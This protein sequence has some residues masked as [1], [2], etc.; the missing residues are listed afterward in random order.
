MH[1]DLAPL[2]R[3]PA[4]RIGGCVISVADLPHGSR[5]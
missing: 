4:I 3:T 1:E 5:E 2:T